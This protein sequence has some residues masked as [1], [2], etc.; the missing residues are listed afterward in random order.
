MSKP[1]VAKVFALADFI[2]YVNEREGEIVV[3]IFILA[4][5]TD[6]RMRPLEE[7]LHG[8]SGYS[9]SLPLPGEV[10]NSL[11]VPDLYLPTA[12]RVGVP[13]I[14][15]PAEHITLRANGSLEYSAFFVV[16]FKCQMHYHNY[17]MDVQ[18]CDLDITS[19]KYTVEDLRLIWH[20]NG[21]A[22]NKHVQTK[23]FDIHILRPKGNSSF[24]KKH[25]SGSAKAVLRITYF[26][27]RHL[28]FHLLQTYLPSVMLVFIGWLSLLVPLD[29]AYGR[30]VL[31]VTTLLVLV[32][33]FVTTSQ[34]TPGIN[35][36]KALDIWLFMCIFFVFSA[37]V[38]CIVDLR[39]LSIVEKESQIAGEEGADGDMPPV[40]D[41][42]LRTTQPA[43][44]SSTTG[45][46]DISNS[47]SVKFYGDNTPFQADKEVLIATPT[48]LKWLRMAV[49]L[50]R[51]M[52]VL[53]PA[54]FVLFTA[55]YWALYLTARNSHPVPE[56]ED[57]E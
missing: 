13:T 4:Y 33:I 7:A 37:I 14:H 47:Y 29:F 8:M 35:E 19:Y 56:G 20:E 52:A 53:Y 2:E 34:I 26:M 49:F 48:V 55:V 16:S 17:P 30:M 22:G 45:M 5:W 24:V 28:T 3:K 18:Q 40:V 50:E 54:L 46:G 38:D 12:R 42:R 39:F 25:P 27:K 51:S 41:E 36:V 32:S 31:S 23:H 1:V 9:S 15:Q 10:K 11:W 44:H 57:E 6:H 43:P 21:L